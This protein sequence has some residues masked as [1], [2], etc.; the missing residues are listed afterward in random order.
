LNELWLP[1]PI[2]AVAEDAELHVWRAELD[3][4][5]A[6][7]EGPLPAEDR[8]RAERILVEPGRRRW[9]AAR[10]A[11]RRTL[12]RYLDVAAEELMLEVGENGKPRIAGPTRLRF[13]LSHSD[14]LALIAVTAAGEVGIDIERVDPDRDFLE[15]ARNGLDRESAGL[16]RA[17]PAAD[18]PGAFYRAWV[19]RE[20]IGKCTGAGLTLAASGEQLWV[21]EIDIGEGWAAAVA[22][23]GPGSLPLRL[24]AS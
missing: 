15:L 16:V 12:C 13:N 14:E 11:L 10:W 7:L 9:V 2:R 5:E 24:F 17:A 3:R 19:R 21:R 20:A 23:A 8:R 6:P 18:R 22:L 4:V 1:G